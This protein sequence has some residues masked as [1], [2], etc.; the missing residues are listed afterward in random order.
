MRSLGSMRWLPGFSGV[1]RASSRTWLWTLCLVPALAACGSD[2]SGYAMLPPESTNDGA[3]SDGAPN[4]VGSGTTSDGGNGPDSA[5]AVGAATTT[6]GIDLSTN[7][8]TGTSTAGTPPGLGQEDLCDS[9][10]ND[11]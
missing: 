4:G 1:V 5:S 11:G 8:S 6:V 2:G 3:S 10:D 7:T 9:I